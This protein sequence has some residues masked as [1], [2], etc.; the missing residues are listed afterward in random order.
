MCMQTIK[1]TLYVALI[2]SV[3]TVLFIGK[4]HA[5]PPSD[6]TA[7]ISKPASPPKG[8]KHQYALVNGVKIHYVIGGKAEPLLL[9]FGFGQNWYMWNRL[10]P[11]LSNIHLSE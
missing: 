9:V 2:I 11:E 1:K 10:L 8:F 4:A 3:T 5:M 6:G 7:K